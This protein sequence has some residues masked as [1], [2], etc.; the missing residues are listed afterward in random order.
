MI[1]LREKKASE[2]TYFLEIAKIAGILLWYLLTSVSWIA[3][4][5]TS[6]PVSQILL[7]RL[8]EGISGYIVISVYY[9]IFNYLDKKVVL[10]KRYFIPLLFPI[11][12][13]VS[14]FWNVF[15]I[16]L[17][18][19]FHLDCFACLFSY[20]FITSLFYLIPTL[21]FTGLYYT[22]N[23][24]IQYKSQREK[25]LIATNLANEAQLQM[26]RYQ[27]NPHF[28]FN[29]L[30]TIRQMVEENKVVARKMITELSSFFRY[31]LS[32]KENIDTFENEIIA[33]KN[34]FEIQKIRFEEKLVII[35]DIDEQCYPVK[36]PFFI[37]L[38][39]IENAV[40]YGLQTSKM[41]LTIKIVA[42]MN[43]HLEINVQNT[44]RLLSGVSGEDGTNTGIEN[45]RKRL[46][47]CYPDNYSFS[48]SERDSWVTAQII[49]TDFKCRLQGKTE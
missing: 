38:P 7:T 39:L 12:C 6:D 24:W 31:S 28:L 37:V 14:I 16:T 26:L 25:A 9:K 8:L 15:G 43:P 35:Y 49:I 18:W 10:S 32:Q 29:T 21:A 4:P 5:K 41:P 17:Q 20:F 47:L 2:K 19:L 46:E 30:N 11:C 3:S 40:K 36:L 45:I 42:K 27:I 1:Y 23:H 33:I 48:L 13:L 44:G 22:I 34:Y